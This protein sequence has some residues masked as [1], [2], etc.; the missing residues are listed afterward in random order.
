MGLLQAL[1]CAHISL[2]AP[3]GKGCGLTLLSILQWSHLGQ[4]SSPVKLPL[5]QAAAARYPGHLTQGIQPKGDRNRDGQ[6]GHCHGRGLLQ[7]HKSGASRAL[8]PPSPPSSPSNQQPGNLQR[9][10]A[11][12]IPACPLPVL[13]PAGTGSR[14]CPSGRPPEPGGPEGAGGQLSGSCGFSAD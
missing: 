6:T 9:R 8:V 13:S 12:H 4:T 11:T 1:W 2:W 3:G 10:G 5:P 7:P 14:R